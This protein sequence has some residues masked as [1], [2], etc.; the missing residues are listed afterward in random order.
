[1]AIK[2]GL[3]WFYNDLRLHD[4]ALLSKAAREVTSLHCV[5]FPELKTQFERRFLP[6]EINND[7]KQHFLMQSVGELNQSLRQIGQ[8][9]HKL[10][11]DS[12]G[13]HRSS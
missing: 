5:F 7:A 13:K 9:L 2:R 6:V 1:M 4:N 12:L 10:E 8:V 3:Y 11:A